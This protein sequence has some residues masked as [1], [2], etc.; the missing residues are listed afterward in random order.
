MK[1]KGKTYFL[2]IE[3][4][5]VHKPLKAQA[6]F[7]PHHKTLM[8]L[9]IIFVAINLRPAITAA[10][11][12]IGTIQADLQISSSAAGLLTTLPLLAFAF[13]S[14]LA[15]SLGHKQGNE[16]IILAG[17]LVLFVGIV[18]RSFGLVPGLFLGTALIGAG[19]AVCN[20][21]LPA[22]I[23]QNYPAQ[24]GLL[25][26][27]YSTTMAASAGLAAGLSAPL[28]FQFNLGWSYS[29]LVWGA[30]ALAALFIW[31]PQV[32]LRP[33]SQ[34]QKVE[35]VSSPALWRSGLAW[36]VTFYMGSQSLLFYCIIT[37][38]PEI[39]V[40]KGMAISTAGWMLAY[41]QFVGLP[42]TF[43]APVLANRFKHQKWLA[44]STGVL[45][46]VGIAGLWLD[47]SLKLVLLWMLLIAIGSGAALSLALTLIGLRSQNPQQASHLSGMA[48]S[49]GY[50]FAAIGPVLLGALYDLTQSWTPAILFLMATAMIISLTG[51]GAG[52]NQYV[53]QHEKQAS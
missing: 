33:T 49:V 50:L 7:V 8:I 48:Q 21:L 46:L 13:L 1:R 22:L 38:L 44:S 30:C 51:L 10:G 31:L 37:W 9:G 11:P 24:V 14:P 34:A 28:A 52:R 3:V 47:A 17:L 29:L 12:L 40:S 23:K 2:R 41:M 35:A 32:N 36:L 26:G 5:P 4:V 25:T 53:L 16:R 39:L 15:P 45:V 20:V 42:A 6:E 18:L 27:L 19:I 43:I